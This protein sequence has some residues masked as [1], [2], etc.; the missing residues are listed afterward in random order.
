MAHKVNPKAFRIKGIKDWHSRG[1]YRIPAENLEEDFR[2]KDFLNKFLNKTG[3][4]KIEIERFPNK[5]NIIIFSARPGLIIGRG[6]EGVERLKKIL[7]EK[8]L[9]ESPPF[10]IK[11]EDASFSSKTKKERKSYGANAAGRKAKSSGAKKEIRIEIREVKNPWLSAKLT[12]Q[13]VAQQIEKRIPY[14][15][16]LKQALGKMSVFKEIKGAK[17]EV[18]GRLNGAEI[19]RREWLK[20]GRLPLQTIRA[21]VD[22]AQTEA[23]CTYGVIGVKVW[24]YKGEKFD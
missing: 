21:D 4:E 16:V 10:Y 24:I 20:I 18:S 8:I 12:A 17:V 9:K 1:F 15:R 5:L 14:R 6:G 11:K 23:R 7:E 22:Y 13:W 3:I 19:A 2:I